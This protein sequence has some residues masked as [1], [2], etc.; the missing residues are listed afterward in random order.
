VTSTKRNWRRLLLRTGLLLIGVGAAP[1]A[2]VAGV[3]AIAGNPDNPANPVGLG[4]LFVAIGGPGLLLV[5]V[6]V[7]L[8]SRR[9]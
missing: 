1:L 7:A 5:I 6:G 3:S 8:G 9:D 4:L 2:I